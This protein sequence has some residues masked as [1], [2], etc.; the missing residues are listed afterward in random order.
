MTTNT[1]QAK[2]DPLDLNSYSL[3][4]LPKKKLTKTGAFFKKWGLPIAAILFFVL[5]YVV[6]IPILN[7]KQEIMFALFATALFLWI[8]E[9]LPNYVT[10]MLLICGLVLTGILKA[11]PAMATLGDPVIWL[12]VSAFV[13]ASALVKTQ[14]VKRVALWLILR[15]GRNASAIFLTFLGS[16][17]GCLGGKFQR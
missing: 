1:V 2:F 16:A 14:L 4:R 13:L 9:T 6:Q 12:N 11:K 7:Q 8:S 17:F 10:S 3:N 15:F 5:A